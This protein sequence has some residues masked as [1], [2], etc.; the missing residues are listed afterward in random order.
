MKAK[1]TIPTDLFVS[2]RLREQCPTTRL[3]LIGLVRD[4][5]DYGRGLARAFNQSVAQIEEVFSALEQVGMLT[6]YQVG[7]RCSD[8]LTYWRKWQRIFRPLPACYPAS[9]TWNA[10]QKEVPYGSWS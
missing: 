6:C 10:G 8:A 2:P 5:D 7:Q 1:R 9:L 4:A 3:A